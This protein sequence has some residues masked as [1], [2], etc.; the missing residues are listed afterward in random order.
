VL[1]VGGVAATPHHFR[2]EPLAVVL[3]YAFMD[4]CLPLAVVAATAYVSQS[5]FERRELRT[6]T[7]WAAATVVACWVLYA[8]SRS[9]DLIAGEVTGTFLADL[10]LYGNLGAV[11]GLIAG[12]NRARAAQNARLLDRTAAQ[13]DALEFINHLLRHNVLNGLQVVEGYADLLE[14]RVDEEGESYLTAIQDRTVHMA[15]LVGNVRVLMRT[16]ADGVDCVPVSVSA[17]LEHEVSV[18]AAGHPEATFEAD[19]P[20]GLTGLADST[21]G[22]VFE[23]LL[24]NAVV[25]SDRDDPTVLVSARADGDEVVVRIADDGPGIPESLREVYLREGEQ[26]ATSTGDGLGLYLASTLVAA[27]GGSFTLGANEPRGATVELRLPRIE[28]N[29]DPLVGA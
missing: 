9:A 26:S 2:D 3:F 27:Y 17:T 29:G 18:A 6:V 7:T 20:T 5:D 4:V 23:N 21:L 19:L 15:D 28:A 16:L 25:H 24:T 12:A 10:S 13:Q 22:A 8:W 11:L 1:V 14:A